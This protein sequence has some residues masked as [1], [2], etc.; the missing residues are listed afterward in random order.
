MTNA[1]HIIPLYPHPH[2][3]ANE[4]VTLHDGPVVLRDGPRTSRGTGT[5]V[6]RFVPSTGLRLEVEI[7]S[8]DAPKPGAQV[9]VEIAGSTGEALI[10]RLHTS[11]A[12]GTTGSSPAGRATTCAA[13][14]VASVQQGSRLGRCSQLV[15]A[16]PRFSSSARHWRILPLKK[17]SPNT[18][19]SD[20]S[21]PMP[22][23]ERGQLPDPL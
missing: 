12:N 6:L 19:S 17:I 5:L 3:A 10:S 16:G 13:T 1:Q 2:D 22:Q 11:M 15:A 21:S 20:G 23:I 9:E 7:A 4:D 8:G 14:A 18:G